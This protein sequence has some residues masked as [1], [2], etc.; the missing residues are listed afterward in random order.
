M[1]IS[2]GSARETISTIIS[3]TVTGKFKPPYVRGS[4]MPMRS[5]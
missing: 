1:F 5:A 3:E 2:A 4:V